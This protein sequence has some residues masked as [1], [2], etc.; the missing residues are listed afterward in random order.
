MDSFKGTSSSQDIRFG[1]K[2]KKLMKTM[3]FP[4]ELNT[5]VTCFNFVSCA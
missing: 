1:D 5:K 4:P 2:E 3:K